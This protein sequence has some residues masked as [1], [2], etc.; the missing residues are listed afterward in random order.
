MKDY[1]SLDVTVEGS[2]YKTDK[3]DMAHILE[4]HH[5]KYWDGSVKK[6]QTFFNDKM[7]INDVKDVIKRLIKDNEDAVKKIGA[8]GIGSFEGTVDGV[9]YQIGLNKG[10]VGQLYP[11]VK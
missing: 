6:D 5:P 1:D 9:T 3:G 10:H 7:T 2:V 4:R 8:N 11:K